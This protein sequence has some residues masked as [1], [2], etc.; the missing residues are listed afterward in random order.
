MGPRDQ[1]FQ[2]PRCGLRPTL[3]RSHPQSLRLKNHLGAPGPTS[4]GPSGA[5]SSVRQPKQQFENHW[6]K[7]RPEPGTAAPSRAPARECVGE[8][9]LHPRT[10][11][12]ACKAQ[13]SRH[14]KEETQPPAQG[15]A[16]VRAHKLYS[17]TTA[18]FMSMSCTTVGMLS[19]AQSLRANNYGDRARPPRPCSLPRQA[20]VAP[21]SCTVD[22]VPTMGSLC[23][24]T[25]C[26]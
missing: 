22:G 23:T 7:P 13:T 6:S 20:Q 1:Y 15:L 19:S 24:H 17:A 21:Y 9:L 18:V 2:V 26:T 10:F 4:R 3:T 25:L 8:V 14:G 5:R 16:I 11:P 12:A